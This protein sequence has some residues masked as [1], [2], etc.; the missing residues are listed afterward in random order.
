MRRKGRRDAIVNSA[1]VVVATWCGNQILYIAK[2]PFKE[3]AE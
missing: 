1:Q 2:F 3:V